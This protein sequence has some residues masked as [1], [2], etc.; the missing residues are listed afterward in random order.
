MQKDINFYIYIYLS[1][2]LNLSFFAHI[3]TQTHKICTHTNTH[4]MCLC[5]RVIRIIILDDPG[6]YVQAIS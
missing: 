4:I 6:G 3:Q 2:Y 5:V 1:S